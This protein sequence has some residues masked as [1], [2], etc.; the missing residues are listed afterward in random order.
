MVSDFDFLMMTR[1]RDASA[2][3][4]NFQLSTAKRLRP[5]VIPWRWALTVWQ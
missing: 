1:D 4:F 5:I 3:S 2:E